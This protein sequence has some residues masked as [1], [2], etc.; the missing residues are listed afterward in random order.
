MQEN[1]LQ[2]HYRKD[3]PR[4]ITPPNPDAEHDII[5]HIT[6]YRGQKT[7]YT[8]VSE[9]LD[10][11]RHFDGVPYSIQPSLVTNDDHIF[12]SHADIVNELKLLNQS[13][14][15]E[16]RVLATRALQLATRAKEALIQWNFDLEAVKKKD[17][18]GWCQRNIQRYFKKI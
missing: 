18:I 13:S 15:R 3:S 16:Q 4:G 11:I 10:S 14:S 1:E 8:S 12:K 5:Q 7:P 17:R 2:P 6:K 9:S